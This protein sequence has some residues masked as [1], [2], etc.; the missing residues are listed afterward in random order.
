MVSAIFGTLKHHWHICNHMQVRHTQNPIILSFKRLHQDFVQL[1]LQRSLWWKNT[2]RQWRNPW[3]L[4]NSLW[5]LREQLSLSWRPVK[6]N[7]TTNKV[8]IRLASLKSWMKSLPLLW[9]KRHQKSQH[10]LVFQM[11]SSFCFWASLVSNTE[12]S[13]RQ[14]PSCPTPSLQRSKQA[15]WTMFELVRKLKHEI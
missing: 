15:W 5:N 10:S 12:N 9:K 1:F 8:E 14:K 6:E 7:W 3:R 4:M 2:S 13:E 11:L